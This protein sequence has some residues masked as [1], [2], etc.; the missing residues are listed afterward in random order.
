MARWRS[1]VG[2]IGT[3]AALGIA[4]AVLDWDALWRAF[5]QFSAGT[6]LAIAMLSVLSTLIFA[7]R[8]SILIA[9][10]S[11]VSRSGYIDALIGLIFN[12]VTPAAMGADAYRVLVADRY[13][14]GRARA[15][16]LLVVERLL[17]TAGYAA[18]FLLAYA[19]ANQR[20]AVIPLFTATAIAMVAIL[21]AS[22]GLVLLARGAPFEFLRRRIHVPILQRLAEAVSAAGALSI[23]RLSVASALSVVGVLTWLLCVVILTEA[24]GLALTPEIVIMIAVVTEFSRF[25]PISIQGIG[26]R[27]ATFAAIAVIA[28]G[29]AAPAFAACATAYVLHFALLAVVGFLARAVSRHT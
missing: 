15:V 1:A 5:S 14:G 28:G 22:I 2:W 13:E 25:L 20:E 18:A 16:G 29:E 27:E 26:V 24:A 9:S 11:L 7:A 17:G 19:W 8:W 10:K 23:F 12:L 4:L 21:L 3:V 6:L